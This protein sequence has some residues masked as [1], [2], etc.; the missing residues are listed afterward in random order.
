MLKPANQHAAYKTVSN[1]DGCDGSGIS[2]IQE[3]W[4][5]AYKV[6]KGEREIYER[7]K[8]ASQRT[9]D[10]RPDKDQVNRCRLGNVIQLHQKR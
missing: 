4:D 5:R 8:D 3:T 7:L 2:H 9:Q 10:H 6:H 1:E